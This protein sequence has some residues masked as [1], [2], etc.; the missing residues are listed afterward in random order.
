MDIFQ[1]YESPQDTIYLGIAIGDPDP[2]GTPDSYVGK[3]AEK[4][5]LTTY[6]TTVGNTLKY[7]TVTATVTGIQTVTTTGLATAFG[8]VEY[9]GGLSTSTSTKY[10]GFWSWNSRNNIY[11]TS[12]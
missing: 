4:G 9:S 10:T 11:I 6:L 1:E 12:N 7:K 3:I 8:Q 2:D 5:T